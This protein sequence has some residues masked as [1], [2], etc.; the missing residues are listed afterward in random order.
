MS[1]PVLFT[2][3]Q[4]PFGPPQAPKTFGFLSIFMRNLPNFTRPEDHSTTRCRIM[5]TGVHAHHA[6][7]QAAAHDLGTSS[8]GKQQCLLL[9]TLPAR[10][11][12]PAGA[13]VRRRVFDAFRSRAICPWKQR[14][15][16]SRWSSAAAKSARA[17]KSLASRTELRAI[18]DLHVSDVPLTSRDGRGMP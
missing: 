7:Q 13:A 14:L 11:R 2:A 15:L 1:I 8:I 16:H 3:P 9:P 12:S 10:A 18:A 17:R 4:A 5:C 6:R